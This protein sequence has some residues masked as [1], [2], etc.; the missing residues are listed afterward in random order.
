MMEDAAVFSVLSKCFAPVDEGEW[1]QITEPAAWSDFLD[2]VRRLLQDDREFGFESSPI[3]RARKRCPL[4][5]FLSAGEVDTL[6][7]PPSYEE[8]R[9]F[10]ARHFTGGLPESAMPVESL[11]ASW[12]PSRTDQTTFSHIQGLYLSDVAHYMCSLADML[13]CEVPPMF[14]GYPDHLCLELDLMAVM[15]RSGMSDE[16]RLFLVERFAWVGA[17]RMRLLTL[18][19]DVRFYIGLI[20][21]ILGIR[22]QQGRVEIGV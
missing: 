18:H 10:S 1:D 2:G 9:L 20:D 21:V 16:A 17:Y 5:E 7:C 19:D 11:Y 6:F 14:S 15:L 3:M 8:K 13:G 22:I 12:S 4:Q